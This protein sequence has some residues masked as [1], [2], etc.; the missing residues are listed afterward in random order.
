MTDNETAFNEAHMPT[1]V[2]SAINECPSSP[3]PLA[4]LCLQADAATGGL[5]FE[6]QTLDDLTAYTTAEILTND[7]TYT[8]DGKNEATRKAQ[9][10]C[11]LDDILGEDR[12][13]KRAQ[14]ERR[15]AHTQALSHFYGRRLR[16]LQDQATQQPSRVVL[17]FGDD[18]ASAIANALEDVALNIRNLT[19][20]NAVR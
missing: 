17:S 4:A 18:S 13:A 1:W 7:A 20:T 14:T 3:E 16:L 19:R 10:S 9:L 12:L 2:K 11:F 8:I 6:L 5:A 15:L